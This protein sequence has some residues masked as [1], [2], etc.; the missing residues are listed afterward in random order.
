MHSAAKPNPNQSEAVLEV[1]NAAHEKLYLHPGQL[2]ASRQSHAVTT[3]LG[4]CVAVCLWDAVKK[5][6]GINHYLLPAFTG[7][8]VASPRFGNVAIAELIE[9]LTALGC[10]KRDLQ[11]K[12][13]G[14]ACVIAAF[15]NRA[16]H[17]GW[18]NVQTAEKILEREDIPVIGQDIGGDKGRKLIFHTDDG[19]AWV[20]R[21]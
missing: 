16:T 2:F 17:L 13:F 5:I 8:G 3:I 7:D 11:A 21:L 1:K 9:Q 18:E 19:S 15:R 4:S 20:K 12:L 14:G 6:G 10:R